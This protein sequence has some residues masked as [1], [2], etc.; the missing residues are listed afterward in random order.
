MGNP[1]KEE[2]SDDDTATEGSDD[3]T[4][5]AH[6]LFKANPLQCTT[7]ANNVFNAN[8][9]KR[10]SKETNK[11]FWAANHKKQRKSFS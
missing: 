7:T 8:P 2:E 1:Y 9:F 3:H 10:I 4:A 5:T 6:K 11:I